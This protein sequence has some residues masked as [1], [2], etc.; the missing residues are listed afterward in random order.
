MNFRLV[1]RIFLPAFVL[2]IICASIVLHKSPNNVLLIVA[3]ILFVF[4]FFMEHK[5]P[6][7]LYYL[8]LML[9]SGI[10]HWISHLNWCNALYLI[11]SIPHIYRA[12]GI[13]KPLIISS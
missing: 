3:G 2:L 8:I 10:F 4:S 1:F 11:I 5:L 6:R 13:V 12:S 9:T 7:F